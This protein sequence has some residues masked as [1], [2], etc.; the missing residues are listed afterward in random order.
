MNVIAYTQ[1]WKDISM[2]KGV[3]DFTFTVKT[4]SVAFQQ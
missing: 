2:L 4:L 3:P 1:E